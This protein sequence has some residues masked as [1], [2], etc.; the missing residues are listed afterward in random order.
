MLYVVDMRRWREPRIPAAACMFNFMF[1]GYLE[2]R[3]YL[4]SFLKWIIIMLDKTTKESKYY[5]FIGDCILLSL[6]VEGPTKPSGSQVPVRVFSWSVICYGEYS[7]RFW[8]NNILR[9]LC[10]YDIRKWLFFS[11]GCFVSVRCCRA[12]LWV[13]RVF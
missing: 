7:I 1:I 5:Y 3:T 6:V 8:I 9:L 12:S 4:A 2:W 11:T 13:L 10:D